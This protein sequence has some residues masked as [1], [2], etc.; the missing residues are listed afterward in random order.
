MPE[1]AKTSKI[2]VTQFCRTPCWLRPNVS[3]QSAAAVTSILLSSTVS[4][5]ISI[6]AEVDFQMAAVCFTHISNLHIYK[7]PIAA[8]FANPSL[9]FEIARKHILLRLWEQKN[10]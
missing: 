6:V 7:G 3:D 4:S 8:I 9:T 2:H 5:S 10:A 1:I